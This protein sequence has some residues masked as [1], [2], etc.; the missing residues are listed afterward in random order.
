VSGGAVIVMAQNRAMRRFAEAGATAPE[1]AVR[2]EDL[3]IRRSWS[4][5][6]MIVHGVFVPVGDARFYIDVD[7]AARFR[8]LRLRRMLIF[9]A[10]CLL[11]G[12]GVL[13]L[14]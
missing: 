4:I 13:L 14:R 3:G 12:A 6:R 11:I 5:G 10:V 8:A 2:M 7:A 1:H 9:L